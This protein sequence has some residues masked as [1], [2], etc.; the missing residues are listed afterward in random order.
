MDQ[1]AIA[2]AHDENMPIFVC[3]I[4]DIHLIGTEDIIGTY[5][6]TKEHSKKISLYIRIFDSKTYIIVSCFFKYMGNF[7]TF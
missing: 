6:H 3:R 2:L 7:I 5:V 4:E 1:S